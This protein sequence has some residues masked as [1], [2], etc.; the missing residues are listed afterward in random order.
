VKRYSRQVQERIADLVAL[1]EQTLSGIRVVQAFGLEE[2]ING[3][4]MRGNVETFRTA[5]RVARM[6]A[7]NTPVAAAVLIVGTAGALFVGGNEIISGRLS[8]NGLVTF[9]M[10]MQMLGAGVGRLTRMNMTIQ[11]AAAS[12]VR[13]YEII[14]TES[15]LVDAPDATALEDIA[16]RVTFTGVDFTYGDPLD[17]VLR[18]I[19]LDIKPGE[20]VAVAGPS[21]AGKTTLANLVP[22]LYD[23]TGG[24]V[25]VDGQDVRG[26][27]RASLRRFMGIVPQ[28]TVLFGTSV[29]ENISYGKPGSTHEELIEAAKAAHA[30]EFIEALPEGYET[31]IGERGAKLSGGQR[32]RLAI[33]RALLRDPRILILDEATSSLDAESESLVQ[34]AIGRL[35]EGRTALIIAHRLSTIRDADR[36]VVMAQGRIAEVGTHAELMAAGGLYQAL[37]ETQAQEDPAPEVETPP[38]GTP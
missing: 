22:R 2:R 30:H 21:G 11:Q 18:G 7:I 24:Q 19:D 23:V 37:Y 10:A 28:E 27:T 34:A 31:Q 29:A 5:M 9:I 38:T 15:D 26:V 33:A 35:L 4:F 13:I 14:D 3:L 20:V 36:I 12:A 32:Q 17:P 6:R 25:L 1:L 8:P 16:G